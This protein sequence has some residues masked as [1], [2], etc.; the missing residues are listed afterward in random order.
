M[1]IQASFA[2][3]GIAETFHIGSEVAILGVSLFVLGLGVLFA[4]V[5]RD[6]CVD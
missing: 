4:I 5:M 3:D 6:T 1:S 2:E